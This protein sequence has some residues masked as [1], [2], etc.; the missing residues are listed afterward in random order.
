MPGFRQLLVFTHFALWL[1]GCLQFVMQQTLAAVLRIS[2]VWT[3]DNRRNGVTFIVSF[4]LDILWNVKPA[5][6][7]LDSE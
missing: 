4:I 5:R 1:L 6:T 7:R 2:A 3:E